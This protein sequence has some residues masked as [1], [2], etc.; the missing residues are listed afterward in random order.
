MI[1]WLCADCLTL[2]F[3]KDMGMKSYYIATFLVTENGD[4][5][6]WC[7]CL[8][9]NSIFTS[10]CC[11]QV[12]ASVTQCVSENLACPYHCHLR[13]VCLFVS[14]FKILL[15]NLI[16]RSLFEKVVQDMFQGIVFLFIKENFW[17]YNISFSA[18]FRFDCINIKD[19]WTAAN[20]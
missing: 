13:F 14:I 2:Y 8:Q 5:F 20:F 17:I 1:F 19:S 9:F 11:F 16:F 6:G 15:R 18:S 12:G 3:Q 10:S 4:S 7:Q